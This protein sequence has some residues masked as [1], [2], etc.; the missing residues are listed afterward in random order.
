[1]LYFFAIPSHQFRP[2]LIEALGTEH[3]RETF[4]N[5][6]VNDPISAGPFSFGQW[7]KGSYMKL[8]TNPTYYGKGRRVDIPGVGEI[9]EGPHYD[10]IILKFY[11]DL[12]LSV[13]EA[14][15]DIQEG[16]INYLYWN[17][18]AVNIAQLY[19]NPYIAVET[20]DQ[21]S[22]YYLAPNCTR[23]PFDDVAL[24]QAL[25]YMVDKEFIVDRLWG[26]FGGVAHS[27][28]VPAA[29]E[30][31]NDNVDKFGSGMSREER[32][33]KAKQILKKAGYTVPDV[34]YPE[35][36][37]ILPNGEEMQPFEIL[38]PWADLE[39]MRFTAG[40]MIQE[41]WRELGVPVTCRPASTGVMVEHVFEKRDFDWYILGWLNEGSGYPDYLFD[42]FSS[43]QPCP[44]YYNCMGYKNPQLDRYLT[45]L[46][47]K[48]DRDERIEAAWKAQELVTKEVGYCPLYYRTINE[49][50]R[51]DTFE[52]WF[53]QLGGVMGCCR[54][55]SNNDPKSCLLY[56]KPIGKRQEENPET[57]A[58][59]ESTPQPEATP[60]PEGP[61]LGTILLVCVL[62]A[63]VTRRTLQESN[64]KIQKT[65]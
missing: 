48:C 49:A 28:V 7:E 39:F 45:D 10:G 51:T 42:I 22:F 32:F 50:H 41:W 8:V 9:E 21:L 35:G 19:E 29:G 36:V 59:P 56:L 37:L 20:A 3:P 4:L 11:P 52:G 16:S 61:C 65:N 62:T 17:L 18:N 15:A 30:W 55:Y 1:M 6:K 5:M 53:T 40:F 43:H 31:Y 24:R 2:M 12:W 23:K 54:T 44:D 47:T 60:E 26:K 34:P 27:V 14:L 38:T 33:T 63:G 57:S 46:L 58:P 13:N 25:V 64:T